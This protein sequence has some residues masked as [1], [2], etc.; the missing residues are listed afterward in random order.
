MR[1][2]PSISKPKP[3]FIFPKIL[4]STLAPMHNA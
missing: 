1:A 4:K 2:T 3:C